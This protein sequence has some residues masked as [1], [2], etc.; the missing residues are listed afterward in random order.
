MASDY[1]NNPDLPRGIRNNNPGNIKD[2]GTAWQGMAGSDGTFIIFS[3]MSWG[4]RA[5]GT[6]LT[7]M[8][9]NGYNTVGTL[10]PQWSATDQAAYVANVAARMGIAPGDT[11]TT[12]VPTLSSLMRAM[13]TQENGDAGSYVTDQDI[14]DGISKMNNTLLSFLQAGVS[15]AQENPG[16]SMALLIGAVVLAFLLFRRK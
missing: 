3:D 10:I 16:T 11:I 1:R 14:A 13:I 6:A 15:A 12:D 2:D 8:I 4:T 7:N 5:M 9:K